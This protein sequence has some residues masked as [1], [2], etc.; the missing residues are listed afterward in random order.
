MKKKDVTTVWIW[1]HFGVPVIK[2]E[3]VQLC[4]KEKKNFH[5][6]N[7]SCSYDGGDD[8]TRVDVMVLGLRRC[9]INTQIKQ[10]FSDN[11]HIYKNCFCKTY[12]VNIRLQDALTKQLVVMAELTPQ[13]EA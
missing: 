5:F 7:C 13:N 2:D 11:K 4:C 6:T 8:G 12:H 9:I 1:F 10:D 3:V